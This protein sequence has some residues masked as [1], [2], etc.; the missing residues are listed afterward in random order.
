MSL[1]DQFDV[2]QNFYL[3][4]DINKTFQVPNSIEQVLWLSSQ[5]S[6]FVGNEGL[7]TVLKAASDSIS[8]TFDLVDSY[9]QHAIN[10]MIKV[11]AE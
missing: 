11:G 3:K 4:P 5:A 1:Q 6:G 7:D 10:F 9:V 8:K 2:L